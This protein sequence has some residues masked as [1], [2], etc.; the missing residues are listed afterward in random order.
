MMKPLRKMSAT[1]FQEHF[2]NIR[3]KGL[4]PDQELACIDRFLMSRSYH[5]PFLKQKKKKSEVGI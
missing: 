3:K 4:H 1:V 2:K 5:F